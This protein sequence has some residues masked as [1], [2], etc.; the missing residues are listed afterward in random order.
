MPITSKQPDRDSSAC[1]FR[2]K[3]HRYLRWLADK[4]ALVFHSA[5]DRSEIIFYPWLSGKQRLSSGERWLLTLGLY[6]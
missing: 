5:G 2:L 6:R 3:G 1:F 4:C